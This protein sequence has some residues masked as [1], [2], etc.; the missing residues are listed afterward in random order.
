M[1]QYIKQQTSIRTWRAAGV[2]LGGNILLR[3]MGT[4][5]DEIDTGDGS[6][7]ITIERA[8]AVAPPVR[9][10]D[11]SN[12]MEHGFHQIYAKYFLRALKRQAA[13]RAT[14][15]PQWAERMSKAS[16][17][18]IREFDETLTAP[19]AGFRDSDDYYA[20]G[21]SDA[22]IQKI[23][24]PTSVL[25]DEHDPIVPAKLFEDLRWAQSTTVHRT[26][27]GGHVGYL[28]RV[29]RSMPSN[30]SGESMDAMGG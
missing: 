27:F 19:L 4:H 6:R 23:Q 5:A 25:I 20:T 3:M 16:F 11:C 24:V 2:S 15:W 7:E 28:Q 29:P 18:S 21:S 10:A 13:H 1:L 22:L 12:H 9:L 17:R 30:A 8:V 14:I 26:Q